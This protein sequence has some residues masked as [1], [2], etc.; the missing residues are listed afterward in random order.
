MNTFLCKICA[1]QSGASLLRL[2]DYSLVK[3]DHCGV[4][5]LD[6]IPDESVLNDCYDRN[7]WQG[8]EK[9][10]FSTLAQTLYNLR[11]RP[12]LGELRKFIAPGGR[13]LDVGTGDGA[14]PLLLKKSGF[15]AWGVDKYSKPFDKERFIEGDLESAHLEPEFFDAITFLHVLE[16]LTDPLKSLQEAYRA[17]KPGGIMVIE[18]PNIE[19]WGFQIFR[20]RWQPLEIPTHLTFFSPSSLGALLGGVGSMRILKVSYFSMRTFSSTI[21]L[22]LCPNLQPK[23]VRRSHE[24]RYPITYAAVYLGLQIAISPLIFISAA[25]NRGCIFRLYARKTG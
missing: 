15:D 3:C 4:V 1:N 22:S 23:R 20:E 6:P 24:G 2:G 7:Y 5:S 16:H 17:L 10:Q 9:S 14:W 25:A 12:V 19:S 13:T 11:M 18:V 8:E 21:A